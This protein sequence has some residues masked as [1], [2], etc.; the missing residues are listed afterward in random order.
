MT[1]A[2]MSTYDPNTAEK[3]AA[4]WQMLIE[5]RDRELASNY[6]I[7]LSSVSNIYLNTRYHLRAANDVRLTR[8]GPTHETV[9]GTGGGPALKIKA[10]KNFVTTHSSYKVTTKG[11]EDY[12]GFMVQYV[13]MGL[14]HEQKLGL[15]L[16]SSLLKS[17]ITTGSSLLT[18]LGLKLSKSLVNKK[19]F[20]GAT[21]G[22]P[23]VRVSVQ[24]KHSQS[25]GTHAA[26]VLFNTKKAVRAAAMLG[27]VTYLKG[28][29]M[30][31]KYAS[32]HSML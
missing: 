22:V 10:G 29:L 9:Y 5:A 17:V 19:Y 13:Y 18:N 25:V 24:M 6:T 2:Y 16:T 27:K 20:I 12:S 28:E 23:V 14:Y 8:N 32:S 21:L 26:V 7:V 4:L 31:E 15:T 3:Q 30:Q 1:R 11:N